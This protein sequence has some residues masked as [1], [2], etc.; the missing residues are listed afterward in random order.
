MT[1]DQASE[2]FRNILCEAEMLARER[3][4][5][6]VN[7]I[8]YAHGGL[9]SYGSTDKRINDRK[10]AEKMMKDAK[11][12]HYPIYISWDSS[13]Q[14]SYPEHIFRIREA[15]KANAALGVATSP[16][17]LVSDLLSTAGRYPAT[18][19]YQITNDKNRVA[20]AANTKLLSGAWK[21]ALR[22]MCDGKLCS[23]N[24][25]Y[26]GAR[27]PIQANLSRYRRDSGAK[28]AGRATYDVLSTP[29][30]YTLG[31]LYHSAIASSSWDVMKRRAETPFYPTHY[32]DGRWE[33]GV[34][35]S[36]VFP[37]V[38]QRARSSSDYSYSITLVGHS[39]GTM[40]MNHALT[41]YREDFLAGDELK[42]I[43][44]MAAAADISSSLAALQPVLVPASATRKNPVNFYNLTLN[45]VSEVA[46]MHWLGVLPTGSLL[47]SIDQH[48][49]RP[50]HPM[51]RT[52]GSEVNVLTSISLLDNA[53]SG[54]E[55]EIVLKAFDRRPGQQYPRKHGDFSKMSFWQKE[56]WQI[57]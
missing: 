20:S 46:E 19:M 52:F 41:Q 6:K 38:L 51:R 18:L 1:W 54:A 37:V 5:D 39:M 31:S 3:G 7:I 28:M 8:L 44:Y 25:E 21:N 12:W 4:S 17:I 26:Q 57:Q 48:H 43:V 14:T 56:M 9:N 33:A 16:F 49:E 27:S 11:D 53:F 36:S 40:I 15:Y 42:N 24:A 35:G 55:G 30:R 47:V 22:V 34:P 45:R 29:V 50:E 32:F 23:G 10:Q 13:V 2:S